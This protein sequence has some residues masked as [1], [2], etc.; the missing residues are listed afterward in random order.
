MRATVDRLRTLSASLHGTLSCSP[1]PESLRSSV[2]RKVGFVDRLPGRGW[3]GSWR[4]L[5][6][7]LAK[8]ASIGAGSVHVGRF[9]DAP[10]TRGA[11]LAS[12]LRGLAT[13]PPFD[14]ASS[15]AHVVKHWFNGRTVVA[16]DAPDVAD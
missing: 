7:T 13:P 10:T 1:V 4:A 11:I 3:R 8:G 14:I 6:A 16:P 9:G 5:A 2:V 12:H 15:D